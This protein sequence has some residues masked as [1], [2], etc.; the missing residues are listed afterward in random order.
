MEQLDD[1]TPLAV[2]ISVSG[3]R[4]KVDFSGSGG[5]HA[6]NL[7]ATPGIVRSVLLYVLRLWLGEQGYKGSGPPPVLPDEVRCEVA[8][9]YIEAFEQVTGRAFEPDLQE[10]LSRLRR[11]LGV[12]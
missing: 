6:G 7:N 5:V 2:S 11:N 4:M 9:R 1:G 3:G 8:R 12:G 10:P